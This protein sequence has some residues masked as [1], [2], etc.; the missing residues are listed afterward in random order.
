MQNIVR[1]LQQVT[2]SVADYQRKRDSLYAHLT[3]MGYS[4]IKPG[5]AFYMFPK[6]LIEDDVAFVRE[7]QQWQVLTVPGSGFGSAGYFRISYCTTDKTLEGSLDGF[8]KVAQ[9]FGLG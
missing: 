1:H 2:V 6:S 3:E 7:L 5:G 9:K 8:R 4:I